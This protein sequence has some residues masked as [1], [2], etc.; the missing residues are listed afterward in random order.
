MHTS[1]LFGYCESDSFLEEPLQ[2]VR[3]LTDIVLTCYCPEEAESC[4]VTWTYFCKE[5]YVAGFGESLI[6]SREHYDQISS[7]YEDVFDEEIELLPVICNVQTNETRRQG[8]LINL[9]VDYE[10]PKIEGTGASAAATGVT[11]AIGLILIIFLVLF[12]VKHCLTTA[13]L[14]WKDRQARKSDKGDKDIDIFMAATYHDR[15]LIKELSKDLDS[16]GYTV[17]SST[18]SIIQGD[19]L[20]SEFT[21]MIKSAKVFIYIMSAGLVKRLDEKLGNRFIYL[22]YKTIHEGDEKINN[23]WFESFL[24]KG[25]EQIQSIC[26]ENKIKPVIITVYAQQEGHKPLPTEHELKV[27]S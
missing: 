21:E 24:H 15:F 2:E 3:L 23:D 5:D 16:L 10:G 1:E 19:H 26:K 25:L 18:Q 20:T 22:I 17:E 4:Q 27:F 8:W 9:D 13:K 11:W 14:W 7:V 12:L 6:I